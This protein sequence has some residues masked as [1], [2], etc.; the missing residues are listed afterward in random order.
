MTV[1]IEQGIETERLY[2]PLTTLRL[3][4]KQ[5][6]ALC[7]AAEVIL[8]TW[9]SYSD[10]SVGV[11]AKSDALHNTITPIAR[12]RNGI[13][14][15]DPVLRNNRTSEAHPLGI[16]HPHEEIHHIKKENIGLI[17]VMGLAVLPARLIREL[18]DMERYVL[19]QP[20]QG[21]IGS[22]IDW[23]KGADGKAYLYASKC[24]RDLKTGNRRSV[25]GRIGT[26]RCIQAGSCGRRS[27]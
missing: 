20:T 1:F 12:Q 23:L 16:F 9:R 2:W 5:I 21:E 18:A 10:E 11:I 22:H 19:G 26:L 27:M 15:L 3:K 8:R 4:G 25:C 17:E 24:G 7:D 14:E 6:E 13:Y